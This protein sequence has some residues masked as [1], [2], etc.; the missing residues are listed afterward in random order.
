MT[1]SKRINIFLIIVLGILLYIL[2]A[3][4]CNGKVDNQPAKLDSIREVIRVDT[5]TYAHE[6]DSINKLLNKHYAIDKENIKNTE[7]LIAEN[8]NLYNDNA[9][10]KTI[11][12]PDTCKPVVDF[13]N[14]KY[15]TYATQTQKTL[16]STKNTLA[17]LS[18]T[19]NTQRTALARKDE[20]YEK[21]R[22]SADTCLKIGKQW[23][24]YANKNKQRSY[25]YAG[26]G[27]FGNKDKILG[28]YN[29]EVGLTTKKGSSY[30]IT[31]TNFNNQMFYGVTVRKRLFKL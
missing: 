16:S 25:I 1:N 17:G 10:L 24:D 27:G 22:R 18:S 29:I 31:A 9:L 7:R 6:R 3:D 8:I 19:I 30:G 28:A 13:L 26:I 12:F 5:L 15:D 20:L 23:E 4:K 21:L 14:K 2:F 11:S